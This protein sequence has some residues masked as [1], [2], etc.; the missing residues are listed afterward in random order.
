M[1]VKEGLRE[2]ITRAAA[3]TAE[4]ATSFEVEDHDYL[5]ELL[6]SLGIAALV[7]LIE[8]EWGLVVED[9]DLVPAHFTDLNS[10]TAFVEQK[11]NAKGA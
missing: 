3:A 1:N 7:A 10:L 6:D 11:V 5:P 2:L 4:E 8:S 9:D